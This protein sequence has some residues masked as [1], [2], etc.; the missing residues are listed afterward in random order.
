MKLK[1]FFLAATASGVL[2]SCVKHE[3]IPPPKP[4]VDLST[5]FVADTNGTSISYVNDVDGFSV[6]TTSFRE[7]QSSPQLSS[8]IYFNTIR[9]TNYSDLF[10]ISVGRA[11]WDAVE[12]D[13]PSISQFKLFFEGMLTPNDPV[14]SDGALNG[15][16]LEWRD[17]ESNLWVSNE[18]SPEPQTFTFTSITQESDEEGDYIKFTADFSCWLYSLDGLDSVHFENG[19]YISYFKNN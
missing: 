12:G 9:S 3:V 16:M 15:I 18:N 1:F 13:L 14:Y 19:T 10:K 7:L 6:E 2:V 5:S 17:S 11:F 8:I 4:E